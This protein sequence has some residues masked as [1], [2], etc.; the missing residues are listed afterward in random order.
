MT[1][2]RVADIFVFPLMWSLVLLRDILFALKLVT[3][4]IHE[5]GHLVVVPFSSSIVR[6]INLDPNEGGYVGC[7]SAVVSVS[8]LPRSNIRR[9][10][11]VLSKAELAEYQALAPG[12]AS[13]PNWSAFP[14]LALPFG[15]LSSMLVGGLYTFASFSILASK[16]A[17]FVSGH[18]FS[19][20]LGADHQIDAVY[21]HQS[22][23]LHLDRLW[24][25]HVP[26]HRPPSRP[27]DWSLVRL[28][29]AV[30]TASTDRRR[31][32]SS[33]TR[34]D[35][36]TTSCSLASVTAFTF[37]W[38][39]WTPVSSSECSHQNLRARADCATPPGKCGFRVQSSTPSAWVCLHQEVR[40]RAAQ[41]HSVL[42]WLRQSG[43]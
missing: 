6:D 37:S 3:V 10:V 41:L 21:R 9:R 16:I 31:T 36:G 28:C 14:V 35:F 15:Y 42:T 29:W 32:G 11:Q 22:C 2:C 26:L 40:K 30:C 43:P 18:C 25:S 4:A 7:V 34:T 13:P 1:D 8:C 24:H 38:T 33:T 20:A 5:L 27:P 17:S 23:R 19:R 39:C 12:E